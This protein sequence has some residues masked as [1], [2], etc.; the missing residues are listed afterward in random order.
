MSRNIKYIRKHHGFVRSQFFCYASFI[1]QA[2]D[3]QHY[4]IQYDVSCTDKI[5]R[6]TVINKKLILKP[7]KISLMYSAVA[8]AHWF[9][10]VQPYLS[11]QFF[12][13]F[14]LAGPM[15]STYI[16]EMKNDKPRSRHSL[17]QTRDQ[18]RIVFSLL[19][20]T[21]EIL[22]MSEFNSIEIKLL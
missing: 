14:F 12:F 19:I 21:H 4:Q 3:F 10:G 8:G 22:R 18:H 11:S 20:S 9:S 15:I 6:N 16:G 1:L 17:V 2:I 7:Y 5:H 13:F